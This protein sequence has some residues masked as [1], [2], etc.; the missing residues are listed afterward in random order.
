MFFYHYE[1]LFLGFLQFRENFVDAQNIS[2]YRDW[3]PLK[4]KLSDYE[5]KISIM[6]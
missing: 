5:F 1:V 3:A 6:S 4:I 2:K